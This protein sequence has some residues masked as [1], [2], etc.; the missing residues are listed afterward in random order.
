MSIT[1]HGRLYTALQCIF[2]W[3]FTLNAVFLSGNVV[4]YRPPIEVYILIWLVHL[5]IYVKIKYKIETISKRRTYER[6]A[7]NLHQQTDMMFQ[8]QTV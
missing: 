1:Q 8:N 3:H 7:P 2:E 6:P 5:K 4:S